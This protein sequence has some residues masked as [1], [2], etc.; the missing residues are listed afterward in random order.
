MN[1]SQKGCD[2]SPSERVISLTRPIATEHNAGS[3]WFPSALYKNGANGS[4]YFTKSYSTADESA[5]TVAKTTSGTLEPFG[6]VD[7]KRKR[8]VMIRSACGLISGPRR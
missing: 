6:T 2:F 8:I 4:I 1:E 3:S 7:N 5:P